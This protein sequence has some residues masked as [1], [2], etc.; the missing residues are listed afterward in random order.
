M[1]I[2]IE[3]EENS[4]IP[5][6]ANKNDAGFD[7]RSNEEK[8]LNPGER[9]IVSTGLKI[10]IQEGYMGIIK[11]RSGLAIKN[12]LH[13]LAGVIDSGYRGVVGVV[14]INLSEHSF[15]IEK[16]MR[17]A[18]MIIH[19]TEQVEFQIGKVEEDSQRGIGGFGSSG[20]K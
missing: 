7:L 14:I 11:D 13:C 17:I 10:K 6:Y 19:K 5:S 9:T 1:K 2:I 20:L 12:G 4:L 8:I 18:Q 16:G 15:T 3:A